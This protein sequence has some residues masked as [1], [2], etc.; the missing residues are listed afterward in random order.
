MII[1]TVKEIKQSE[2]R[3]GLT[4]NA[5]H[6][7]I[8]NGHTVLIEKGAG[9]GAGFPDEDYIKAGVKVLDTA[10]E[11]W[12]TAEMIVKVKEPLAEEYVYFRPGLII[13]TFLHLAADKALT[14]AML[15]KQV[16]GIAYETISE[17]GITLPVLRPMSE[18][19]GRLSVLEG[20]KY[21]QRPFGGRGLLLS[22]L[23]GVKRARVMIIGAGVVG[24]N[25]LKMAVGLEARVTVLDVNLQ[26]L[27]EIDSLYGSK[28]STLYSSEANIRETI[29][30]ADLVIGAVL[31]PG[32]KAPKLIKREY[33]KTMRA[34]SVIVDVAIDQGGATEVGRPTTHLDP[35]F[36]VDNITHYCVA[37]MPG[38]VAMTT[39]EALN[40]ATI[41][42][43]LQIAKHG[44][45][46]FKNIAIRRGLNTYQGK[47]VNAS[48]ANAFDLEFI[49]VT[50]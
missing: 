32:A 4:P 36:R 10:R 45:A 43:G 25:A 19:A 35:V 1:G 26:R 14:L 47:V 44:D 23:P 33:Y 28:V 11:V 34:G 12:E 50:F 18:A 20:V 48:V 2:Y 31:I 3:V 13:Y 24:M 5:A 21:L 30:T 37:N 49:D 8:I 6:E 40:N 42:Y 39:T 27:T 17:D 9:I 16:T 46:A 22:G 38:S 15:E 7:Y 29:K 41:R